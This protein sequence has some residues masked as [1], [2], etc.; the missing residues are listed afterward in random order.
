M[1][2]TL[3]HLSG[4]KPC[5]KGRD[6]IVECKNTKCGSSRIALYWPMWRPE[7]ED[8]EASSTTLY[9]L[10]NS[11]GVMVISSFGSSC[12]RGDVRVLRIHLVSVNKSCGS[13]AGSSP[14]GVPVMQERTHCALLNLLRSQSQMRYHRP[15]NTVADK[16]PEQLL[17]FLS[18]WCW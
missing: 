8:D 4:E 9:V 15:D 6:I 5:R 14:S 17:Q 3:D 13:D 18:G 1:S 12:G 2:V 10:T 7:G 16:F 11:S